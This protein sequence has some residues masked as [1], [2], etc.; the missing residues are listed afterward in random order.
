MPLLHPEALTD[1]IRGVLVGLVTDNKDKDGLYR[2]QVKYA[3]PSGEIK[4]AWA[5]MVTRMTGNV[6]GF[7]C[8]PE[9][10]DEV[11]LRFVNGHPDQPVIIGALHNGK[12]KP[13]FD[14]ADGKNDLR[15]WYS[16]SDHHMI[17]N[18]GS[19]KESITCETKG[20]K[21]KVEMLTADKAIHWT[22]TKDVKIL[23]G[24][25]LTVEAGKDMTIK[26]SANW[27]H[28]SGSKLELTSDGS[29]D[30]KGPAG[31]TIKSTAV[32]FKA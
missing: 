10:D 24:N 32:S 23:V 13:P 1:R 28:Q 22:A 9:K 17:V 2:V 29:V 3:V 7:A 26:A 5:R 31:V 19:G 21:T 4:S 11:L 16:R 14:N 30:V 6:W 8:L 12:D 15:V 25:K 27:K 20:T 18:D